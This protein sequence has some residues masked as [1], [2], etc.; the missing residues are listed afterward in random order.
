MADNVLLNTCLQMVVSF[1]PSLEHIKSCLFSLQFI[2]PYPPQVH[3]FV[4]GR[5][6]LNRKYTE[7]DNHLENF[8]KG[9]IWNFGFP[10]PGRI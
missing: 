1:M 3:N 8:G 4:I 7:F 6:F 2:P 9:K 10:G 5:I